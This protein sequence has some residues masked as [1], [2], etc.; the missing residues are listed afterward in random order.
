VGACCENPTLAY[1]TI[2]SNV[3]LDGYVNDLSS[4]YKSAVAVVAPIFK[5]SGMKTKVIEAMSYGKSIIGTDEAFQGIE[6]DFSRAILQKNSLRRLSRY[7]IICLTLILIR[8]F[9]I[10][11]KHRQLKID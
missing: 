1:K 9:L 8:Y 11:M 3:K 4:Y 5:G 6:C 10:S 7:L 2:P